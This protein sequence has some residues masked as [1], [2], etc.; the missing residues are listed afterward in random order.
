MFYL[1]NAE[2]I[3]LNVFIIVCCVAVRMDGSAVRSG[4]RVA[5]DPSAYANDDD[6]YNLRSVYTLLN[7]NF[8]YLSLC[9]N[10]I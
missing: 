3:C 1:L 5:Q 10:T 4:A 9:L 7:N 6:R 8:K 2:S